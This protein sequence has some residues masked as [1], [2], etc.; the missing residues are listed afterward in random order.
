MGAAVTFY[1]TMKRVMD[2]RG[3]KPADLCE[4]TGLYPSFFS[5]L[6]SGHTKDVTWDR[7]LL[8]IDALGM[9]PDEFR[10]IQLGRQAEV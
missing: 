9:T 5:K 10:D 3:I 1:E 2:E 8:I 7:A 6:K 4:R